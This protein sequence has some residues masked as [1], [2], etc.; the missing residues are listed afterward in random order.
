M[1]VLR[2]A[3]GRYVDIEN[4][5]RIGGRFSAGKVGPILLK[6]RSGWDRRVVLIGARQLPT[7]SKYRRRVYISLDE[8]LDF[9]R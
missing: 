8:P 4:T 7:V 3:A 9:R 6:L 1:A 5:F 2:G